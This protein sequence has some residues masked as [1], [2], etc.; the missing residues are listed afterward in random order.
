MLKSFRLVFLIVAI[1]AAFAITT[2]QD[3]PTLVIGINA[4]AGALDPH[5]VPGS[6]IG[7]RTFHMIFD[8][9]TRTDNAGAVQPMLATAWEQTAET[10]WVFTLREG[11]QFHDGSIMTAADVAFSLNRLVFGEQESAIR[12]LFAPFIAAVEATGDLEVTITTAAPDPLLPLR[13]STPYSAIMPQAYVEATAFE[14]LQTTP[15]GAGPYRV[16]EFIAGDRLVLERHAD[17]W[18]GAPEAATITL[19]LIPETATRVAALQAG[20]VDFITTVS[21]DLVDVLDAE[22]SVRVD[23]VPVYNYM[24]IYFNTK[25][26]LTADPLIRRALSLAIDREAIAEALWGGRVRV[27]N[28]YFLPG[29]FGYDAER[30][31]FAYDPE[32]AQALLAEAGYAGEELAFTPPGTYYTNGQLVTDAIAEMWEAIG[33]TVAYEPLDTAAWAD[34]SLGGQNIATLQSFGTSGDPAT[35]SVVQAWGSWLGQYYTPTEEFNQLTAEAAQSLDADVRRTNY[36]RVAEI[37]DTDVP[38]TPLYQTVEFYATR[39]NIT[40]TPHQEFY[41]DVRPGAFSLGS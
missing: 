21:P 23:T 32:Q 33:V 24:L 17:Y 2:A 29:E 12:A 39:E 13:L 19:R 10:T 41:I 22:G 31:N 15:V 26:G 8:Q 3:A 5:S 4:E 16:T 35:N 1:V 20:E 18:M 7:N 28:D 27:M 14:T 37:M 30:P 40:W 6:I 38:F 25:T 34:R 36:R 9:L 11:V